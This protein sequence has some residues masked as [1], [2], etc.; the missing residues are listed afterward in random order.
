MVAVARRMDPMVD[1]QRLWVRGWT[2]LR[3]Q[4]AGHGASSGDV[5]KFW[6]LAGYSK[7]GG[8]DVEYEV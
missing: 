1:L 5:G 7:T 8:P 3:I 4:G 6:F 2:E